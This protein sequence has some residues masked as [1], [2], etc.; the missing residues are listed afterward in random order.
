M[1]R[2]GVNTGVRFSI[3]HLGVTVEILIIGALHAFNLGPLKDWCMHSTWE[4]LLSDCFNVRHAGRTRQESIEVGVDLVK[5]RLDAWYESRRVTHPG[6]KVTVVQRLTSAM[7][8]EN[9]S[10]K[11][12]L[13]AGETKYYCLCL[14]E[15][16]RELRAR[17]TRS[18]L[19]ISLGDALVHVLNLFEVTP[20][21]LNVEQIQETHT[22]RKGAILVLV[23]DLTLN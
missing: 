10:R 19:W 16:L 8:G 21:I 14:C 2:R 12:K 5:Q 23:A 17:L 18:D 22:Y 20:A 11:L 1:Q 3:P 4:L 9:A 13:K 7:L 6:E 15:L